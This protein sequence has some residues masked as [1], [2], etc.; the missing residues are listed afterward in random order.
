MHFRK[1][2]FIVSTFHP[3]SYLLIVPPL[4]MKGPRVL[5]DGNP[6]LKSVEE[7][8]IVLLLLLLDPLNDKVDAKC[9]EA[10]PSVT[11]MT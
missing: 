9:I 1:F 6:I 5:E 7:E 10:E 3:T 8:E 2:C 11:A 4:M